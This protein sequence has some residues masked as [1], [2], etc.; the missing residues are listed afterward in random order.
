MSNEPIRISAKNLGQLAL[1]DFCPRCFWLK[2][3]LEFKL[4]FQIF[5]GVFSTIDSYSKKITWQCFEKHRRVP[6]WFRPFGEFTGMVP[7]PHWSRFFVIDE[8]TGI[9][10]TGI[11]DELLILVDGRLFVL[12][13]KTAKLTRSQD[14]L[15]PLYKVQLN[16]YAFIIEKL[17]MGNV[18]GMGLCYYEPQ[19]DAPIVN[20]V[21]VLQQDGFVMPFKAHLKNI[22]LELEG[23]VRPLLREVRRY[24]A[25]EEAP[26]G[27][28]G[29]KDCEIVGKLIR[30]MG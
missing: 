18:G 28:D 22:E 12:D 29:C 30:T 23:I 14:S 15:L 6:S 13:Y 9:K 24:A 27:R 21:T 16:G 5:P 20:L 17:G 7:V 25:M 3:K 1:P 2:L 8:E 10:L 11:P 26:A 19:G 4:P